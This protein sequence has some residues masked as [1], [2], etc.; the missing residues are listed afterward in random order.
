M[1]TINVQAL[2]DNLS[3]PRQSIIL[4]VV[5][6]QIDEYLLNMYHE[7]GEWNEGVFIEGEVY[8]PN[9]LIQRL[10]ENPNTAMDILTTVMGVR[11]VE[12]LIRS[13]DPMTLLIYT[14]GNCALEFDYSLG[15]E[16]FADIREIVQLNNSLWYE[17]NEMIKEE[18]VNYTTMLHECFRSEFPFIYMPEPPDMDM[19]MDDDNNH[20]SD[21]MQY[22][23]N[24]DKYIVYGGV[25]RGYFKLNEVVINHRKPVHCN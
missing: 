16:R 7:A 13:V 8:D 3:T 19:D 9:G 17:D 25:V 11:L 21:A 10:D 22:L 23:T 24:F 18:A 1:S 12:N 2:I 6:D 5:K 20:L 15:R 14:V 4:E